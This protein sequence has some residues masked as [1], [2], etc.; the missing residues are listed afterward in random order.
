VSIAQGGGGGELGACAKRSRLSL[1]VIYSS[2]GISVGSVIESRA[3]PQELDGELSPPDLVRSLL[4][5][6]VMLARVEAHIEEKLGEAE[7]HILEEMN[8]V[9]L[10]MEMRLTGLINEIARSLPY[11]YNFDQ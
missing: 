1:L 8:G 2:S 4:L 3:T 6:S 9:L 5:E 10:G 7:F 11:Q